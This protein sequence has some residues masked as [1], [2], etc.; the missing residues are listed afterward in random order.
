MLWCLQWCNSWCTQPATQRRSAARLLQPLRP[1]RMNTNRR[2][3]THPS[4]LPPHLT[5]SPPHHCSA[6]GRY[7][8]LDGGLSVAVPT[9]LLGLELAWRRHGQLPW[10]RLV[11]PAAQLARSGFA[12]HPYLVYV[13]SGPFMHGFVMNRTALRETFMVQE[14]DGSWRVPAVG[15]LCCRRPLLAD[16]LE[17]RCA[18]TVSCMHG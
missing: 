4:A 6:T 12:A 15:E 5:A 17:V 8:Y 2:A 1:P 16:T 11:Q 3:T 14:E 9:E 18:C 7:A 10:A 13:M